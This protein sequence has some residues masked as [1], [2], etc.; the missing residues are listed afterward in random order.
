M[1]I[2]DIL[3]N[4]KTNS[5]IKK[6]VYMI[7]GSVKNRDEITQQIEKDDECIVV[8]NAACSEGYELPSIGT[9]I[10]ASLS[11]SYK[12][13]K[14]ALGRFLRINKLK[15]NVYIH[16]VTAGSVD[17]GVYNAIMKKQDFDIEIY[18]NENRTT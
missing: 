10:F 15:K 18:A 1:Q 5:D 17:E 9:I 14:Q 7:N 8:I 12:D 13:Y 4:L 2:N 3:G 11:F 6:N 16:L